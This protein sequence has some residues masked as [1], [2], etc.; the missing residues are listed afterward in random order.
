MIEVVYI[1]YS[2]AEC[3]FIAGTVGRMVAVYSRY[4][5]VDVGSVQ[6]VQ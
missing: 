5:E 4:S 1:K 3:Q 6:Q 2:G